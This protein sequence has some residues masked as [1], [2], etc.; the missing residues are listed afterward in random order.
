MENDNYVR[1][2]KNPT[3]EDQ[4]KYLRVQKKVYT[5]RS[6]IYSIGNNNVFNATVTKQPSATILPLSM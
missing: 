5:Q 2:K 1:C 3:L 4:R 6:N